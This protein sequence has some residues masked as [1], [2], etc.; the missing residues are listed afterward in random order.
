[1][2]PERPTG[3]ARATVGAGSGGR[4]LELLGTDLLIQ[5]ASDPGSQLLGSGLGGDALAQTR[6]YPL[7]IVKLLATV[8]ATLGVSFDLGGRDRIDLA[9]LVR[10][11]RQ[12][13]RERAFVVPVDRGVFKVG[14]RRDHRVAVVWVVFFRKRYKGAACRLAIGRRVAIADDGEQPC[15]GI[16]SPEGLEAPE[17]AQDGVL[18]DVLGIAR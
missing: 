5:Y 13:S 1:T 16:R 18:D 15:L 12:E 8:G 4:R 7:Q 17:G 6:S 10:Q 2:Q 3:P 9:V 14:C 11:G